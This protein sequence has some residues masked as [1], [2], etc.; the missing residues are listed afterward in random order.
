M[1]MSPA[2]IKFTSATHLFWYRLTGGF[3]GGKF[4]NV[5]ILLLTTTGRKSGKSRTTPL[6]Y[7]KDGDNMVIVASNGG[8]KNNPGWYHN[9]RANPD[10]EV[11]LG[12][13]KRKVH[14]EVADATVRARIWPKLVEI[15]QQ[16]EGYQRDTEREIP[17]VILRPV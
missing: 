3:I 11:E 6:L 5:D 8:N 7:M 4:G 15:Y 13:D 2:L 14:A 12:R 10:V 1:P 17:L 9:I 16:Y